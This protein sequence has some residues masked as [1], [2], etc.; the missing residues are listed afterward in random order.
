MISTLLVVCP[1]GVGMLQQKEEEE[2]E[3]FEEK[4]DEF[5]FRFKS[6]QLVGLPNGDAQSAF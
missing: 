4:E 2:K 6:K 1:E 5:G 3:G